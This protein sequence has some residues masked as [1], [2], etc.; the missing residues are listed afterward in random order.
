LIETHLELLIKHRKGM[1]N[2][3]AIEKSLL[4]A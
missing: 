2:T 3:Q 1:N 4:R